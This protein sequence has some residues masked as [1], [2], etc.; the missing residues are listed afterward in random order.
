MAAHEFRTPAAVVKASLDSLR[1][2]ASQIPAEVAQRLTNIEHASTRMIDL[3][4][5]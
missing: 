2:L 4:N 3:S 1:F 5:N